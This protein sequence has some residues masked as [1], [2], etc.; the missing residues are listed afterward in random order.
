MRIL[1]ARAGS[2]ADAAQGVRENERK[3]DHTAEPDAKAA[4]E[5][6]GAADDGC[7]LP[8]APHD[9]TNM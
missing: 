6:P 4:W 8:P 3:P 5:S 2:T 7:A 1:E 9:R